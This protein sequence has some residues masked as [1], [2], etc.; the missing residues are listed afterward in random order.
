ITTVVINKE[1]KTAKEEKVFLRSLPDGQERHEFDL[2]L[3]EARYWTVAPTAAWLAV[4]DPKPN[5]KRLRVYDGATGAERFI[6]SFDQVV[7]CVA[8]SPDGR[9][10]AAGLSDPSRVENNKIVLLDPISSEKRL[11][12]Q[13]QRKGLVALTFSADGRYLAAGFN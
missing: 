9:S 6:Q 11:T 4:V 7:G 12:L 5:Q 1:D 2:H 3:P 13:T 8:S 10:L